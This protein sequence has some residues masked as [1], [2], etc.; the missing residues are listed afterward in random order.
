MWSI[1]PVLSQVWPNS[2]S[3]GLTFFGGLYTIL[4]KPRGGLLLN[5]RR[6]WTRRK[7]ERLGQAVRFIAAETVQVKRQL[8]QAIG[9]IVGCLSTRWLAVGRVWRASINRR[10]KQCRQSAS[11]PLRH[12][13]RIDPVATCGWLAGK[14]AR[15]KT[16]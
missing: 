1:G 5:S 9:L 6:K 15:G 11:L 13:S 2:R 7:G 16:T 4:W 8:W 14:R 3:I 10:S 12:L